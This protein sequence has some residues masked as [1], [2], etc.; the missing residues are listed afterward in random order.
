[1][2]LLIGS[3]LILPH[4]LF[5]ILSYAPFLLPAAFQFSEHPVKP[6]FFHRDLFDPKTPTLLI[7]G[8]PLA[9]G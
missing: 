2:T 7:S 1:M 9:W 4:A 8:F 3:Q 6:S 5:F